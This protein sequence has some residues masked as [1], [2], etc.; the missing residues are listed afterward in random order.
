[1]RV[2]SFRPASFIES[3]FQSLRATENR[4]PRALIQIC[5]FQQRLHLGHD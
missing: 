5:T 2:A 1:M 3:S 4:S